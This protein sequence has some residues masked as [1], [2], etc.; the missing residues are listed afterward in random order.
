MI[1]IGDSVWFD[2]DCDGIQDPG[3]AGIGGVVLELFQQGG[4]TSIATTVIGPDGLYL[5]NNLPAGVYRVRVAAGNFLPGGPLEGFTITVGPQSM[6][7]NTSGNLGLDAMRPAVDTVDFGYFMPVLGSIGDLVFYDQDQNGTADPGEPGFA[8]VT[9]NLYQDLNTNGVI[10]PGE[11]IVA[12]T[13][14]T[15]NGVYD[16]TGLLPAAYVVEVS[17]VG[18]V[19]RPFMLTTGNE[20]LAVSLMMG[21]DFNDAD[22]GYGGAGIGDYVWFDLNGDGIQ[23][24]GESG[25]SGVE[26]EL[27]ADV[28]GNMMLDAGD[29]L[30]GSVLTQM[31]GF[32]LFDNLSNGNYMVSVPMSEFLAGGPLEGFS[33]SPVGAGGDPALDS[34]GIQDGMGNYNAAV[35]LVGMNLDIDFG[36]NAGVG[37]SIGDFVW[38]DISCDGMQGGGEPG[39]AGVTLELY[40]DLDGDGIVDSGD[41]H[42]GSTLTDGSGLYSFD[43][44]P[45][46]DYLVVISDDFNVLAGLIRPLGVRC[47]RY[48]A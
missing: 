23:D 2:V 18:G 9:L 12:T 4:T 20:P 39:I 26:V 34:D 3:E 40:R 15:T 6:G 25:I 31:G 22:F 17:D 43:G 41:P 8:G 5:F 7:A 16:F 19:L 37:F 47:N 28:N 46:G 10:D 14:T 35:T 42:M 13:I 11:P 21:E 45:P 27:Y 29:L 44:L 30:L 33:A 32:Y 48:R 36:F 38:L 1:P 24:P